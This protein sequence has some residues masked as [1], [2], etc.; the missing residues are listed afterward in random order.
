MSNAS[1]EAG[2]GLVSGLNFWKNVL[3]EEEI[4]RM[5]LGCKRRHGDL[6]TWGSML[7]GLKG[8]A[9]AH[10]DTSSCRDLSGL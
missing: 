10:Y 8:S 7:D 9:Y 3:E 1:Q 4:Q 6:K 5:S 2:V